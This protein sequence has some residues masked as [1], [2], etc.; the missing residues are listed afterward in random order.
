MG[1]KTTLFVS[2]E[3]W[4]EVKNR[5]QLGQTTDDVLRIALELP[6]TKEAT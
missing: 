4:E 3:V 1:K 6:P 5:K 2:V